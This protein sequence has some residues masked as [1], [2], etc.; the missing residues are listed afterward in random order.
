MTAGL[1]PGSSGGAVARVVELAS[2]ARLVGLGTA[3][4]EGHETFDF[5]EQ[6]TFGLMAR[7]FRTLA[8]RDGISI[9]QQYDAFV[10][11]ADL[12]LDALLRQAWGPWQTVETRKVLERL[13]RWNREHPGDPVR[14]LG[15]DG[16]RP[17]V[18]D[19]DRV[20]RLAQGLEP[21]TGDEVRIMLE[22]IRVAH[23][24]GEHVLHKL[25]I[26]PG[27]PFVKTARAARSLVTALPDTEKRREAL[28]LLEGIVDFHANAI[29][30]GYDAAREEA[31]VAQVLLEHH[32]ET[33]RRIV[34]WDGSLHTAA[35]GDAA[36]RHLREAVAQE[37]VAVHVTFGEGRVERFPLPP[38]RPGSLDDLVT[39]GGE[40]T[41]MDVRRTGRRAAAT[42]IDT[43]VVSGMYLP[44]EDDQHYFTLPDLQESFD[45]V[46]GL[47]RITPVTDVTGG[48]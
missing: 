12:D 26:H 41:V 14:V 27:T 25:G 17:L 37:Y 43:R 7:G 24:A 28:R 4:R 44:A 15:V 38:A 5:V 21:S 48:G 35:H 3:T 36:G 45:V 22:S 18:D 31:D 23:E 1:R 39:R 40:V 9:G 30:E 8:L 47:P 42:P 33:G 19:Y 13:R 6:V 34:Y 10:A 20:I 32:A 11:G 16:R 29:G 46:V 2:G